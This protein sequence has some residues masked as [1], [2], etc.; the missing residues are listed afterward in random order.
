MLPIV[1]D[2]LLAMVFSPFF[3]SGRMT[4]KDNNPKS[5]ILVLLTPE[6]VSEE[7]GSAEQRL[8]FTQ[9]FECSGTAATDI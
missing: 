4:Y 7:T 9:A 6:P 5:I 3:L 2:V 8:L 1:S